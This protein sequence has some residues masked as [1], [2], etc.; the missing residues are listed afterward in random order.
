MY[1]LASASILAIDL[2]RHPNGAG[3]ADVVDRALALTPEELSRLDRPTSGALRERLVAGAEEETLCGGLRGVHAMLLA[4]L[5]LPAAEL[6]CDAVTAAWVAPWA[7]AEDVRALRAAWDQALGVVPAVLP[8]SEYREDLL[9]LLED[10]VRRDPRQWSRVAAAH[11]RRRGQLRWSSL[12]HVSCR[13]A[14][15]AGREREVAR[16]QL[17]AARAL[18]TAGVGLAAE[19]AMAVTAGV[20]AVCTGDL[21]DTSELQEAW[22]AGL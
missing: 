17:A 12:M 6:A 21:V 18:A 20:Q 11:A 15:E 3:V 16:A 1:S 2:A 9:R 10:V 4:E 22:L 5:P 19:V 14:V 8:E 13:A 7:D